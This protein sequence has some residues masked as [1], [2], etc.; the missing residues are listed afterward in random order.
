MEQLPCVGPGR[1]RASLDGLVNPPGVPGSLGPSTYCS[2]WENGETS[3]FN[4][5]LLIEMYTQKSDI[6]TNY[7]CSRVWRPLVCC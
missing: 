3:I 6:F 7:K 4:K 5:K 1:A 2:S